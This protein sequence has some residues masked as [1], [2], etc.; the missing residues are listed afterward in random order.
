MAA[1]R[2]AESVPSVRGQTLAA[3][4]T[5]AVADYVVFSADRPLLYGEAAR[6][7]RTA[8]EYDPQKA[9][10]MGPRRAWCVAH[11]GRGCGRGGAC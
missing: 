1:A 8:V 2:I 3:Q 4:A 11:R 7:A 9:E 5:F 10:P 6:L